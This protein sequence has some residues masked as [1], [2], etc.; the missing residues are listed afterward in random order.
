[1]HADGGDVEFHGFDVKTGVV[2]LRMVG[3]CASCPSSTVTMKVCAEN[4]PITTHFSFLLYHYTVP[5]QFN[6]K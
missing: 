3:A 2:W 4:L 6:I 5:L 1:V